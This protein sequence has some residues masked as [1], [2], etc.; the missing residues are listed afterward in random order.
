MTEFFTND[1]AMTNFIMFFITLLFLWAA[2][3][4]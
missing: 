3:K 4:K 1:Q 2:L